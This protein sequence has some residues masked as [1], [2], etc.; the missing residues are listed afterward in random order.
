M[1]DFNEAINKI[2]NPN[3]PTQEGNDLIQINFNEIDYEK[4]STLGLEL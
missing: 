3:V 2:Q 4:L 1:P